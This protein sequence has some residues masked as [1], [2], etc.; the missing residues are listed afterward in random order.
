MLPA[1]AAA[2]CGGSDRLPASCGCT[3]LTCVPAVA[4][5]VPAEGDLPVCNG[6]HTVWQFNFRGFKLSEDVYASDSI[7]LLKQSGIDFAQVR[8]CLGRCQHTTVCTLNKAMAYTVSTQP[9]M[10][11]GLCSVREQLWD[12]L[13]M[14]SA[15]ATQYSG[16][17]TGAEHWARGALLTHR[18][19]WYV[20]CTHFLLAA[21]AAGDP[22]STAVA[23]VDRGTCRVPP[24]SETHF[25]TA[26]TRSIAA[27]VGQGQLT[28]AI[29]QPPPRM[30]HPDVWACTCDAPQSSD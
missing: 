12:G 15:A 20:S 30:Q 8:S 9:A 28:D 29:K 16:H 25:S 13:P 3:V 17:C 21:T 1:A 2:S 10:A 23:S 19:P 22:D 5:C 26:G 24:L 18:P 11:C 14:S 4:P 6:E 7:E 27:A